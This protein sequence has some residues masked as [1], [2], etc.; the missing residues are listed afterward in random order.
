M[1]CFLE[2]AASSPPLHCTMFACYMYTSMHGRL[3]RSTPWKVACRVRRFV[4]Q[5]LVTHRSGQHPESRHAGRQRRH[6]DLGDCRE[7]LCCILGPDCGARC[8]VCPQPHAIHNASPQTLHISCTS[9]CWS[10]VSRSPC[11]RFPTR[12]RPYHEASHKQDL[13]RQLDLHSDTD[14]HFVATALYMLL[15]IP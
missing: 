3:A 2:C 7:Q 5:R 6:A 9:T 10:S 14:T 15:S 11:T 8:A 12:R 13:H 1:W 4:V